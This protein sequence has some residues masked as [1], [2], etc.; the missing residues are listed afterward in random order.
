MVERAVR[1]RTDQ[2]RFGRRVA[3]RQGHAAGISY[4]S[5]IE[6][7]KFGHMREL[8]VQHAGDPYRVFYAFDPRRAAMILIG[9]CKAGDDRF[10]ERMVPWVD[11]IYEAHL[12]E[13][14]NDSSSR[15][16]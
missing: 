11:R 10:Y 8:R 7:S 9:G 14:E 6:G 12:Q 16:K 4:S 5:G 3:C 15:R 13:L 1:A 2:H